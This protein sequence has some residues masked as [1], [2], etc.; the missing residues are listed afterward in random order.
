MNFKEAQEAYNAAYVDHYRRGRPEADDELNEA[1]RNMIKSYL[2]EYP[3]AV[4]LN[5]NAEQQFF[6]PAENPLYNFSC[7]YIFN[8]AAGN[9]EKIREAAE[10]WKKSASIKALKRLDI[11]LKKAN[12]IIISWS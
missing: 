11:E 2:E 9:I 8:G 5:V 12:Y 1:S 6:K 4:C 10:E 3:E 7:D